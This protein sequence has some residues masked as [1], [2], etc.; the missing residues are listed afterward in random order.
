MAKRKLSFLQVSYRAF[1]LSMLKT[2]QVSSPAKLSKVKKSEF[3]TRIKNEW[4]IKKAELL[5]SQALTKSKPRTKKENYASLKGSKRLVIISPKAKEVVNEQ[6]KKDYA[7]QRNI[8]IPKKIVSKKNP[9][10]KDDLKINF[11]PND[12][13]QQEAP[14]QYPVVKMPNEGALLK[15]PRKGRAMGK[16]FKEQVF[17]EAI[18][19]GID[20]AEVGI[21]VHLSIPYFNRPYEPD[22][23]VF[24]K[25]LNL[26][27]DV[28]IDEPYDGYYR[29]PTHEFVEDEK[30]GP[31][32]KDDTRDLFFTES[33]WVVIKFTER[34]VHQQEQQCI[35]L[36]NDVL[37]LL[38]DYKL[39]QNST[40]IQEL[41][42]SYQQAVKWQKINY[43]EKYLGIEQFGKQPVGLCIDVDI[44]DLDTVEANI[45][46]TKK[47]DTPAIDENIAFEEELHH[48]HHK[49][50]AT[51]N[52]NYIS[53]TTII[54]RFFPFDMDRFIKN[55]AKREERTEEDVLNEFLK[56]RNEASDK[57]T[58]MHLQ[59]EN[60]L[61]GK[62]H[63]ANSKEFKMFLEFYEKIIAAKGF[64]F[65][66]AEKK[67]LLEEYNIAGMI[68]ALFK[69]PN[70]EEYLI[71]D[72]KRSKKL[73]VDGYPKKYGF[74][75]ATSELSH[76]DNS[77]YYKY[78]LQQN[79]YKYILEIEEN[80]PVSSM[81]LIV[82]HENYDTFHRVNLENMEKEI[83]IILNSINHKI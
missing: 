15:L 28:E 58:D 23:V 38:R 50:D 67:I 35:A 68:D 29:N 34:Q 43:R 32:K 5:K 39:Q 76:V 62:P 22:I 12:F 9:L 17:Y 63:N 3:F 52:A 55:K 26:Y 36:I 51:G 4:T 57:G 20:N 40:C 49:K 65:I 18:V 24:D 6:K 37:N 83:G 2:Y 72:W 33:G 77:S 14:Y 48:Y 75:S 78:A 71:L 70:K 31:V 27:I 21:D 25:S 41:Q 69:K 53:V 79:M 46:R 81:N 11:H 54:N 16:G 80:I 30:L 61:K 73:V 42:W 13:F 1:F 56:N 10:Q 74:G 47:Y 19:A 64:K 82:L 45:T 44:E 7:T 60:F 8:I 59:I 66:E